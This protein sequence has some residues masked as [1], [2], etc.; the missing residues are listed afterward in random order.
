MLFFLN[1]S[2]GLGLWRVNYN[3]QPHIDD[4]SDLVHYLQLKNRHPFQNFQKEFS[5]SFSPTV[6][7]FQVMYNVDGFLEKNR[8]TLPADIVV[9][10]RTSENKLLQQLFSSPLT[11]TGLL[12]FSG[13]SV[14]WTSLARSPQSKLKLFGGGK[15]SWTMP[16]LFFLSALPCELCQCLPLP[17]WTFR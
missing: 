12:R 4:W 15:L 10:L 8:D 17:P 11:K 13:A 9:V 6:V 3:N 7:F 5:L 1:L 14:E 16:G 2:S